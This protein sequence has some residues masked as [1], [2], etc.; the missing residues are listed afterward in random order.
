MDRHLAGPFISYNISP[1]AI[2]PRKT[3]LNKN[4]INQ[5][6]E[7]KMIKSNLSKIIVFTLCL[8][9]NVAS[10]QIFGGVLCGIGA[11]C[12]PHAAPSAKYDPLIIKGSPMGSTISDYYGGRQH[13]SFSDIVRLSLKMQVGSMIKWGTSGRGRYTGGTLVVLKIGTRTDNFDKCFQYQSTLS[14]TDY[15]WNTKTNTLIAKEDYTGAACAISDLDP[16]PRIIPDHLY[17]EIDARNV[18]WK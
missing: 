9:A 2:L 14:V 5:Q 18:T 8:S 6:E 11:Y 13:S 10:A 3:P 15:D 12:P 7:S 4:Q 1:F 17:Y 16:N